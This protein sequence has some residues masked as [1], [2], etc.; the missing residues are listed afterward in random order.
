MSENV[1]EEPQYINVEICVDN[2]ESADAAVAGGADRLE[3]C[4]ALQLGGLTPTVGFV[5]AIRYKYPDVPLF[6]M[7]RQRAG[8]FVY[9]ADEMET[10]VEDVQWL[11]KAGAT[12]FVFGALT[13]QGI[14]DHNACQQV[15]EAARPFPVTFHRAIDVTFDWRCSL[16][17]AIELGFKA[18]L[19]SGQEPTAL[20]GVH[21]IKE[22]QEK[23]KDRIDILVGCGVNSSN[24]AN[25]VEWTTCKWYHASASFP[26]NF[27]LS[28]V[29][30]GKQDNQPM[31]VTSLDEV[32]ML[33]STVAYG[34]Y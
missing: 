7:I 24:V 31:R 5:S 2:M 18:V 23:Y 28:K 22:M 3:V 4:S 16:E 9:T 21:I 32:R 29:Q 11:I 20:D 25:L 30:M 34:F 14:V 26:R 33:K 1:T 13:I 17:D 27:K 6:C 12:G 10:N 15:I 19:T 8:N